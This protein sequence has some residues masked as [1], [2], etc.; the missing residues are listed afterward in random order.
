[1]LYCGT[2]G[3]KQGL[4][5]FCRQLSRCHLDFDFQIRGHGGEA[6]TVKKWLASAQDSRFHLSDLMS[7]EEFVRAI[8]AADWFVIPQMS[9]VGNSFF[10]SKLIPSVFVGTPMLV[11]SD[12]SGP[13]VDEV[14]QHELGLVLEWGEL[15]QLPARPGGISP[16]SIPLSCAA[17]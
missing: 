12:N 7:D 4:L 5:D 3:K 13:L 16:R 1:M 2:I 10:P 14:S 8:H 11:V 6:A 15:D 17:A 9:G